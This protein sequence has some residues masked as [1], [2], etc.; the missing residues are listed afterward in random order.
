MR[1]LENLTLISSAVIG[2]VIFVLSLYSFYVDYSTFKSEINLALDAILII[3]SG[4]IIGGSLNLRKKLTGYE[5]AVDRAFNDALYSKLKPIMEELALGIIEIN[6]MRKKLEDVERKVSRVEEL[7][8]TQRLAPEE[9]INFYLK[10]FIVML[11][12]LGTFIFMTQYTLP[13]MHLV[14]ILLFLYWWG[15]ITYEYKLYDRGE[16]LVM[17]S[18]P[19][20][21][22]PSLYLLL[23]IVV[24][25]AYTQALIFVA[26]AVYAYY[27]HQL[28]REISS[29]KS[30]DIKGKLRSLFKKKS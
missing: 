21:I 23:R 17:L 3:F 30:I 22:A 13:N 4:I 16:A 2:M 18:A 24:G 26:S 6:S 12:Y 29:G 20:L 19:V 28:A 5:V 8:T 9:K 15:F 1:T 10:A 14:S 25:I 11:F 27:Y 7:A